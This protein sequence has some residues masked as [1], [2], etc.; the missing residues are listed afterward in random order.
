MRVRYTPRALADLQRIHT[1]IARHNPSAAT[2]VI[3]IVEKRVDALSDLPEI[4]YRSD[5]AGV[6]IIL[7]IPYPYRIYYRIAADEITILHVR[8]TSRHAPTT[9]EL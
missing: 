5:E 1:Y 8:H 4:G 3:S 7:A 9:D 2:Q 6:R